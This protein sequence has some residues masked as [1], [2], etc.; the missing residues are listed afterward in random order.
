MKTGSI[1]VEFIPINWIAP[2]KNQP[3]KY[4]DEESLS[5]LADSIAKVG[6]IQPLT[7]KN[8][9]AGKYELIAGER[10]LRAS[11]IAGLSRVPCIIIEASEEDSAFIS[12]IENIQREDLNFV[13]EATGYKKLLTD[14][15]LTQEKLSSIIGKKQSTIANKL[16]ILSLE[17]DVLNLLN[18]N[19]LTE[20]HARALLKLPSQERLAAAKRIVKKGLNVRQTEEMIENINLRNGINSQKRRVTNIF[21]KRI[22]TNTIKT[23]EQHT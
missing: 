23:S 18:K 8:A 2:N 5:E 6:V 1:Y 20:R 19:E 14:Y 13:E 12:I 15:N 16:R 9:G 22:Y 17:E 21:D 10:R 4:F 7:V 3:R 11:Q